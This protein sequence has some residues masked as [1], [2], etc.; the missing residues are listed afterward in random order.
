MKIVIFQKDSASTDNGMIDDELGCF[1]S[2]VTQMY[3]WLRVG[4]FQLNIYI[5]YFH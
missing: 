5:Y 2:Y 4:Y 3:I 1:V